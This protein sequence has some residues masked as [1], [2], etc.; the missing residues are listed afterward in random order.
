MATLNNSK[1]VAVPAKDMLALMTEHPEI[2]RALWWATL[3]DEA[4]LREWLTS[5]GQRDAFPRVAHILVELWLRMRMVGLA[6]K[7]EFP[8]PLTLSELTDSLGLTSVHVNRTLQKL[9]TGGFISLDRR[10][11]TIHHPERL[12]E[13]SGFEPNYLHLDFNGEGAP[14]R[15]GRRYVM[16]KR[17]MQA[18]L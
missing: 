2:E 17:S 13:L 11:L 14:C 6:D 16:E 10:R 9:R 7:N 18:G 8:L 15:R 4:I 5:M 3:V 1:V 12:M